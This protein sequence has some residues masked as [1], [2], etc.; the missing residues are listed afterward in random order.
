LAHGAS[1]RQ[2]QDAAPIVGEPVWHWQLHD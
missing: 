2:R 1:T